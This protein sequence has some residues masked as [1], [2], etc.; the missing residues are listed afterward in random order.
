MNRE[1]NDA[2]CA[3]ILS[4]FDRTSTA[5]D[6][7][8]DIDLSGKLA[9]VTGGASGLGLETAR[10]LAVAGALVT[11]AARD[12]R[13]GAVAAEDL[14]RAIGVDRVRAEHLDLAST[15]SVRAFVQRWDKPLAILVNN[16]GIMACPQGWTEDG[17]ELQLGTNHLGHFLLTRLLTPWLIDAQGA[18]VISL[19]SSA[20][21]FAGI[22][23]DDPNFHHRP[24]D[25]FVAYGQSKTANALFALEHD[26]RFAGQG[27]RAF[28][29]MPG[30]I[31]TPLSRHMTPELFARIGIRMED[32][33]KETADVRYKTAEQGAAT[34]VWAATSPDL[35]G[36][37]GLYLEDCAVAL[38]ASPELPRGAGVHPH[39]RD[40][41]AARR[42]WNLSNELL[43]LDD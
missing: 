2:N 41:E 24:Y 34:S 1:S 25:P 39:A 28:A 20:H 26:K 33:G 35:S 38:P 23:F 10:A 3:N 7:V 36:V 8:R 11:L 4:R 43:S 31:Q 30:V 21:A 42:L 5:L 40:P 6:V 9:L 18:R 17:F 29:V 22:D 14:N 27:I 15:A 32:R 16:A 12:I 37:G 13:V 19:S